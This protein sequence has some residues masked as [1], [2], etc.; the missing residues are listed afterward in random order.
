MGRPSKYNTHIK[1][2][3]NE[4]K[5]WKKN[6]ATDEQICKSLGV[7][8]SVF[9]DAKAKYS[10]FSEIFRLGREL[11]TADL[12]GEL[13]KL[14]KKHVLTTRKIYTKKDEDGKAITY[15]EVTEKE[16]DASVTAINLLLKNNDENWADDPKS[17][18]LRKQELELKRMIAEA[19]NFDFAAMEGEK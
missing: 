18:D 14:A 6:G 16:V 8:M 3:L 5:E 11:F 7:S 12:K 17:M 9:Y 1:P 13:A 2:Y 19:N 10:E 4:I 15:T